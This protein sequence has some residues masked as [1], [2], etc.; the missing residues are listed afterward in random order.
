[1]LKIALSLT[2][3]EKIDIFDFQQIQDGGRNSENYEI[4][5]G[6]IVPKEY[7]TDIF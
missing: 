3:F 5:S 4:Y 2:V 7:F 6:S 1:M